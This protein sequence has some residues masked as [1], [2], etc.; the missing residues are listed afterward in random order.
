MSSCCSRAARRR[1]KCL[2]RAE[3]GQ[4][5]MYIVC[6]VL[7]VMSPIR[8]DPGCAARQYSMKAPGDEMVGSEEAD[9]R[10]SWLLTADHLGWATQVPCHACGRPCYLP[11]RDPCFCCFLCLSKARQGKGEREREREGEEDGIGSGAS[12]S[13]AHRAALHN[14]GRDGEAD[15]RTPLPCVAFRL[16]K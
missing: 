16:K 11:C 1:Q 3:S 2:R 9:E 4:P 12:G 7:P 10:P 13:A 6:L 5:C 15:D 14:S 8:T